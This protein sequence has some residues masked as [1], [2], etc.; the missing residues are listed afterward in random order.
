MVEPRRELV[1]NADDFGWSKSV[2]S[3]IIEAHRSGIVTSASVLATGDAFADAVA[4]ARATPSLSVGVHLSFYRGDTMLPVEEVRSL[5]GPDERFLG[6]WRRIVGRL[7]AGTFDLDQLERELRAQI[8]AVKAAGIRPTHLDGEKHLHLWPSVF[9]VVC[10]LAVEARIPQVRVV[11]EPPGLRVVPAAL[12]L[13]SA[14]DARFAHRSGIAVPDATIG[15]TESPSDMG[16]FARILRGARAPRVE[17]VVH[18]GHVDAQFMEIQ[19]TMPNRLVCS[20]EDE[21]AVLTNPEARVL[22]ERAG[23]MLAGRTAASGQ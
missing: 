4:L 13:L 17:F 14:R 12:G 11:R 19:R 10:R 15:V 20:R 18:P 21:L 5:G 22:V 23:Y 16:A 6:S 8:A 2:N 3:G 1:V 7:I 9:E